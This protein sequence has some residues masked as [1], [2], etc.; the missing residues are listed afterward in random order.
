MEEGSI[1]C[2]PL[3]R[4]IGAL[5]VLSGLFFVGGK[6]MRWRDARGEHGPPESLS[7][8]WKGWSEQDMLARMMEGTASVFMGR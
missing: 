1:L 3:R 5:P 4:W 2:G 7:T 6:E 8:G